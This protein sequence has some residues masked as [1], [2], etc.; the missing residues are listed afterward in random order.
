MGDVIFV[1]NFQLKRATGGMWQ[2][3][4][5]RHTPKTHFISVGKIRI[6]YRQIINYLRYPE[7]SRNEA[8]L[9]RSV[10]QQLKGMSC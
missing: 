4:H 7:S 10:K 5:I 1:G 3:N 9:L 2:V 8:A 6:P